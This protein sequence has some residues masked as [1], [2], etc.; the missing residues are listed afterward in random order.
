[1]Q[2]V[3][4]KHNQDAN[5]V[6]VLGRHPLHPQSLCISTNVPAQDLPFLFDKPFA[7]TTHEAGVFTL[8]ANTQLPLKALCRALDVSFSTVEKSADT[9]ARDFQQ[10]VLK[11]SPATAIAGL[12]P[13]TVETNPLLAGS[14]TNK[15]DF[16]QNVN[17]VAEKTRTIL[18]NYLETGGRLKLRDL[19]SALFDDAEIDNNLWKVALLQD[20]L[21]CVNAMQWVKSVQASP[22]SAFGE[23][24]YQRA[25]AQEKN[26]PR[27]MVRDAEKISFQ[28][29]STPMGI[30]FIA[31][32]LLLSHLHNTPLNNLSAAL[33][34]VSVL[35]P[36]VGNG[37]LLTL[38]ANT[39]AN[40]SGVE[41]SP[42]R[43]QLMQ[44]MYGQSSVHPKTDMMFGNA[45]TLP[46]PAK[47]FDFVIANP[48][49][50]KYDNVQGFDKIPKVTRLDHFIA[51]RALAARKDKGRAVIIFG[52]DSM[53]GTG[54]VNGAA[55]NFLAYVHDH[56]HVE[57]LVEL[58]GD[59]YAQNGTTAPVRI[60][61]VGDRRPQAVLDNTAPKKGDKLPVIPDHAAL[62]QWADALSASLQ[63]SSPVQAAT[64]E[65]V[66]V[67]PAAVET[68]PPAPQAAPVAPVAKP[69]TSPPPR[70]ADNALQVRY[71]S[72]SQAAGGSS[73]MIPINMAEPLKTALTKLV[74]TVGMSVDAYV[75]DRLQYSPDEID[76]AAYFSAEQVDAIA[77][78][79]H[80]VEEGRAIVNA[81]QTGLGKGRFAA[82]MLRYARLNGL[83]PVFSTI[84][85]GLF[86]DI[87]RD[88]ND[89]DSAELFD[90]PLILNA[91][92]SVRD[93]ADGK[94]TL[95]KATPRPVLDKLMNQMDYPD[96]HNIVLTT[97]SQFQRAYSQNK[98][99]Q[100]FEKLC[101]GD[102]NGKNKKV[103]LVCDESHIAAG[104]DSN[105][106]NVLN[107][108]IA[109][110]KGGVVYSSATPFKGVNNFGLYSKIFP[111][112]VDVAGLGEV[113]SR[114]GEEMLESIS[115]ALVQDG[116]LVRREKDLSALT[117][118]TLIPDD[119]TVARN[120]ALSNALAEILN[121]MCELSGDV[122]N[123]VS[124]ANK[125]YA[126][127]ESKI[128]A[129]EQHG[130][131][132]RASS[133][134]FGSRLA[135]INQ[136]FIM[137]IKLEP[138]IEHV[139]AQI[140]K[141][142]KPVIALENTGE[143]L[144]SYVIAQKTE[145]G[146]MTDRILDIEGRLA[147]GDL[148]SDT[149]KTLQEELAQ[150]NQEIQKRQSNIVLDEP[151]QFRD[152]LV[153][154][155]E[156]L[157]EI[158]TQG[159]YGEVTIEKPSSIEF[160]SAVREVEALI[161]RFPDLPLTPIDILNARITAAGY[162]PA[163]VSGRGTFL[164]PFS[165]AEGKEKWRVEV[166]KKRDSNEQVAGFQSGKYDAITITRAGS[167]GISLH[168]TARFANSDSRQRNFIALQK[169]RNISEFMQ[170]LGRTDRK[171]QVIAPIITSVESALPA[172]LRVTMMHNEKLR[173][174]SANVT[175][176]RD[177]SNLNKGVSDFLNDLGEQVTLNYLKEN[178]R[179]ASNLDITVPD[180][181]DKKNTYRGTD[182]PMVNKLMGRLML[183]PVED[184][185]KIIDD[186]QTLF[187]ESLE[188]LTARG[189]NPF[190]AR[191]FDVGGTIEGQTEIKTQFAAVSHSVFDAPIYVSQLHY[192]QTIV[193]LRLPE[194]RQKIVTAQEKL[195]DRHS[196]WFDDTSRN[197]RVLAQA[198][199]DDLEK[200]AQRILP[201][202]G[203]TL[204]AEYKE[205][206][207]TLSAVVAGQTLVGKIPL[208][209][210][211]TALAA[212]AEYLKA[213]IAKGGF[214]AG[215][216]WNVFNA[217]LQKNERALVLDVH[218]PSQRE[219]IY[220]LGKYRLTLLTAGSDIPYTLSLQALYSQHLMDKD[221]EELPQIEK[222]GFVVAL[223]DALPQNMEGWES[224]LENEN[225][226]SFG[227]AKLYRTFFQA[228]ADAPEGEL[229]LSR[230]V[231]M[232][233]LFRATE[234]ALK[235]RLGKPCLFTNAQGERVKSVLVN[236]TI[237]EHDLCNRP[238]T[239]TAD[240]AMA[241]VKGFI[242]AR[243]AFAKKTFTKTE[244]RD[245][246]I[247]PPELRVLRLALKQR[248]TKE[249]LIVS[250]SEQMISDDEKKGLG[251][252][253]VGIRVPY[254][255]K[256]SQGFASDGRLWEAAKRR[257]NCPY[258][259]FFPM[260]LAKH[261]NGDTYGSEPLRNIGG[262][263]GL[264]DLLQRLVDC[265]WGSGYTAKTIDSA[266][267]E[268]IQTQQA[269]EKQ[270]AL[271]QAQAERMADL[272]ARRQEA[273]ALLAE[274][275]VPEPI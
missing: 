200:N 145:Y 111:A 58:S 108:A 100:F 25:I 48:P 101:S 206:G 180:D 70:P 226:W 68:P 79:I 42:I 92:G 52:S 205:R 247:A 87:Y 18:E 260:N 32:K 165:D 71:Q 191:L 38:L 176:N 72:F 60:M 34:E 90:R 209:P 244:D 74:D 102:L 94:T 129:S 250:I 236:Q 233:N 228:C 179:L 97:Y 266:L 31:Q 84:S 217:D 16:V 20:V 19:A 115:T 160:L 262:L 76:S 44:A 193:P 273:M 57:G 237:T 114:G 28:Q 153:V 136:Q 88:L 183:L 49:F 164:T 171:D 173:K 146:H 240:D 234:M 120:R 275:S 249:P 242:A 30:S 143:S 238:L 197:P 268:A 172:E 163:E 245:R 149:E 133:M 138:T 17:G 150:L 5:K 82:A 51:L 198:V 15:Y 122:K 258:D 124:A 118:D 204:I 23:P 253:Q 50:G 190:E 64:A 208:S 142:L 95:H 116:S 203:H 14:I 9:I 24:L 225:E 158:K 259:T 36:T 131:R 12:Y 195:R 65:A 117:F 222:C 69:A 224:L 177:N 248:D 109:N 93:F 185:E 230:P 218:L 121:R 261:G 159:R 151:P 140:K 37:G 41:I 62:F 213:L 219:D 269:T 56:Y 202:A 263:E 7:F 272:E 235:E 46:L 55:A 81:D 271:E 201:L 157:Q 39:Q 156:R 35:E 29:Y 192:K 135:S 6:F 73:V 132:M 26:L 77:L 227:D 147:L 130:S 141:G 166:T 144:A 212:R 110:T 47:S 3:E 106:S 128:P 210:R 139:L 21:E 189:E 43:S 126:I 103:M 86:S 256:V 8:P 11:N 229:S 99:A 231:L 1:M 216:L 104:L 264:G 78:G 134:N 127:A 53:L 98:K 241:L 75:A 274:G 123:I 4:L 155:L 40:V 267:F 167:T 161:E 178:P 89:I 174:L 169:A 186:I 246:V 257:K 215:A 91:D 181:D 85:A 154:M 214:S 152:L 182:N 207:E 168:A 112:S 175:S 61:V 96:E 254:K 199:A 187:D 270:A 83:M 54:E 59:L 80:A 2:W 184:Q 196:Q 239:L 232:G 243:R 45:E 105:I 148:D 27:Q 33:G 255:N 67:P 13:D 10:A 113:L 125:E 22:E 107:T 265:D 137:A 162:A 221:N 211:V 252:L 220:S 188:D 66:A 170:H 251:A 63:L 194:L 223:P 119:E